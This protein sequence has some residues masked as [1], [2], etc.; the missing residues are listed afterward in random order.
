M[1]EIGLVVLEY[2]IFKCRQCIF[3]TC[4]SLISPSWKTAW[5]NLNFLYPR[6]LCVMFGWNWRGSGEDFQIWQY[7]FNL[8]LLSPL[9][10]I[11]SF[12]RNWFFL[13]QG[14][15]VPSLVEI[16][17]VVLENKPS[18]YFHYVAISL[19]QR[20][21]FFIG[22]NLNCLHQGI[23][24][25]KYGGTWLEILKKLICEK[26]WMDTWTDRQTDR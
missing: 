8:L 17:P 11:P 14:C 25:V 26:I 24:Y 2:K 15:S 1:V 4:M 3:S 6:I 7:I 12:K 22:T 10:K 20:P 5:P 21:W 23:L 18:M 13:T 9:S 19:W 16:G